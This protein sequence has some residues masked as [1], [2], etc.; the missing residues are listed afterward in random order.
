MLK[1]K[2]LLT[3]LTFLILTILMAGCGQ[4]YELQSIEVVPTS[5]NLAG[6]GATAQFTV[7][8]KY[9]NTKTTNVTQQ[10]TYQIAAPAYGAPY[11]PITALKINATG[12]VEAVD[13]ACTWTATTT[14]SGDTA[15]TTYS[16]NPYILTVTYNNQ[17]AT[18]FISVASL[19]GCQYQKS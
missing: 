5:P 16:T 7:T 18:A 11:A 12:M 2:P 14:G 8:A 9:S 6:I 13:G 10:A 15:V 1:L 17:K 19:A 4:T 3:V